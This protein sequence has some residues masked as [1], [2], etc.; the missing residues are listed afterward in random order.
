M[1]KQV[2]L[3]QGTL[4]TQRRPGKIVK[5]RGRRR[6]EENMDAELRFQSEP[7]P[8]A[9]D[10][11]SLRLRLTVF[12]RWHLLLESSHEKPYSIGMTATTIKLEGAILKELKEFKRS[13]Q[14]LSA[15]IRELLQ[16]EIQRR[17]MARAAQDYMS[18]MNNN[19]AETREI[20]D[21]SS[22]PLDSDVKSGRKRT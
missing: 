10:A 5:I 20:D 11:R 3:V 19:P 14:S 15:L 13:D 6:F 2:D 21:W 16:S 17:K 12:H 22:T 4:D 1:A 18:F 7:N 8:S 9:G